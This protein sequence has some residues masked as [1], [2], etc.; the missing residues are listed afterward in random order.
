MTGEARILAHRP[1]LRLLPPPARGQACCAPRKDM[2][3]QGAGSAALL[4]RTGPGEGAI[5]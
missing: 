5:V 3:E 1:I 2:N 4:A